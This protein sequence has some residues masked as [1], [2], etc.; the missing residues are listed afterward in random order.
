MINVQNTLTHYMKAMKIDIQDEFEQ[1][2]E[3]KIDECNL[4]I[5]QLHTD[6]E[7]FKNSNDNNNRRKFYKGMVLSS[8]TVLGEDDVRNYSM[9]F[10]AWMA[11]KNIKF[12]NV[13]T[14][15]SI[16][17]QLFTLHHT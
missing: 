3:Y 7:R 16:H 13:T 11:T 5:D 17:I 15:E 6:I 14:S 9:T 10:L 2:S 12:S 4:K 1:K 8:N